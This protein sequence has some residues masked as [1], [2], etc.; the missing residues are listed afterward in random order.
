MRLHSAVNHTII[1]ATSCLVLQ[2]GESGQ[3]SNTDGCSPQTIPVQGRENTVLTLVGFQL[4]GNLR[5]LIP[6]KVRRGFEGLAPLQLEKCTPS[7]PH[8][9]TAQ[10]AMSAGKYHQHHS[11]LHRASTTTAAVSSTTD[12]TSPYSIVLSNCGAT[13]PT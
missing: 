4:E 5:L 8:P 11:R 3:S 13:S 12:T 7:A 2:P 1:V 6:E 10:T 9:T